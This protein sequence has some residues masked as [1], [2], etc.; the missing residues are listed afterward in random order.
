MEKVALLAAVSIVITLAG[1]V[2]PAV[3]AASNQDVICALAPSQ[4]A[5]VNRISGVAGGASATAVALAQATGLTVVSHSSGALI[6]T[7]SGG[8][9]AGTLGMGALAA[10]LIV[11]V[12]LVVGGAAIT[13]ELLCSPVNHPNAV[14]K[15]NDAAKEFMARSK[16]SFAGIQADAT[17]LAAKASI[18]IQS[19]A[20]DVYAY[21]Y[22]QLPVPSNA[23]QGK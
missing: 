13:V 9:L 20:G 23:T 7:G 5:V 10:P 19:V 8:Y 18:K 22:R 4:S 14:A 16:V 11:G 12:G 21:S 2:S 1:S 17:T 15:I 3:A 6:L